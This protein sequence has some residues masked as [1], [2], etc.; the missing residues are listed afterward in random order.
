MLGGR[1]SGKMLHTR[2]H[3][4]PSM[5]PKYSSHQE[6]DIGNAIAG[7]VEEGE[8]LQSHEACWNGPEDRGK[9]EIEP[10]ARRRRLLS[11]SGRGR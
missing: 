11:S 9:P 1:E 2:Q 5:M 4:F 6:N 7:E 3:R 8:V 10:P